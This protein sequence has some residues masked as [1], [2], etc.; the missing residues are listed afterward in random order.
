M[1]RTYM[2]THGDHPPVPDAGAEEAQGPVLVRLDAA[3]LDLRR[4]AEAPTDRPGTVGTGS[5]PKVELSTV[6]VVH[7]VAD[8]AP[9]PCDIAAVAASLRVAHSTASRQVERACRAGMVTRHRD[10]VDPR[11]TTVSLTA[12]G[13]RLNQEAVRYRTQQLA[14]LL[15][16]WPDDDVVTLTTLLERFARS[17][18]PPRQPSREDRDPR[19]EQGDPVNTETP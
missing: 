9:D 5:G 1:Y 3:L 11:H 8:R 18:S 6:L 13:R 7:A 15:S 4:F 2:S 12:A 14:H 10:R 17:A 16:D 19:R